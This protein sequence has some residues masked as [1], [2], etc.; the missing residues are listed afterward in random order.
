MFY[1]D[2]GVQVFGKTAGNLRNY[3]VLTK[4]SLNK[5]PCTYDEEQ[6]GEE[7]PEQYFFEFPQFQ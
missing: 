6:Q 3:P 2:F 5:Y 4:G 1:F 7:E